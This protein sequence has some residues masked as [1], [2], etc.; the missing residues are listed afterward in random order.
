MFDA[1][2]ISLDDFVEHYWLKRTKSEQK[3]FPFEVDNIG[4]CMISKPL[5]PD[6]QWIGIL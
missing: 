4:K 2:E 5:K 1:Q 6:V 3:K